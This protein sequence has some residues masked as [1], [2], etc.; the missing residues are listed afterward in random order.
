MFV[1]VSIYKSIALKRCFKAYVRE[2]K[3]FIFRIR[4]CKEE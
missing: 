4:H 3:G 2:V 1:E